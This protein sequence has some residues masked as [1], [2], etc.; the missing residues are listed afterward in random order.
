MDTALIEHLIERGVIERE[1]L[2]EFLAAKRVAWEGTASQIA[3][4]PLDSLSAVVAGRQRP[5]LPGSIH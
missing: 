3:L 5:A 2:L 4:W 1:P